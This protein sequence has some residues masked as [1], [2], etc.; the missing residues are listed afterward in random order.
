M[1]TNARVSGVKA[2]L[3]C[4]KMRKYADHQAAENIDG[5]S[6]DWE[7]IA[8]RPFMNQ[9]AQDV[10]ED[11]TEEAAKTDEQNVAHADISALA[12]G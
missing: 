5:Q 11:G 3:A 8:L 7:V 1:K 10:A 12:R 9:P 4:G 6:A 2:F